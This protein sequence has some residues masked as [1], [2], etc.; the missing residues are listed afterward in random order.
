MDG[1]ILGGILGLIGVIIT[2]IY[3]SKLSEDNR[4]SQEKM[5]DENKELQKN[6]ANK[7]HENKI[8]LEKY[9]VLVA[10][11][12]S[13]SDFRSKEFTHAINSVPVVFST[14]KEII[15]LH[16]DFHSYVSRPNRDT[17]ITEEKFSLVLK[18]M[19]EHLGIEENI[20]SEDFLR[21][22]S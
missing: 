18:K 11:M 8:W 22:F 13:R 19:F 7:E 4:K 17:A 20:V 10:L 14:S 12:G 15:E 9:N 16:R 5:N 6:L 2:L 3:S 21:V 1:G